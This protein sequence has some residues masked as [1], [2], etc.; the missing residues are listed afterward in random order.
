MR[1]ARFAKQIKEVVGIPVPAGVTYVHDLC[2]ATCK[3]CGDGG[4]TK[5]ERAERATQTHL[6][7]ILTLTYE[8]QPGGKAEVRA[9][10]RA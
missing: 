9:W 7:N 1:P 8:S 4:S 6:S 5:G 10:G 2:P 3:R